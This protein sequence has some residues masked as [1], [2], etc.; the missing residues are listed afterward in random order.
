[1][2]PL[3]LFGACAVTVMLI[4]YALEA[5]SRWWIVVFAAAC[6]ASSAYGWLSGTWP[7]GVIEG[8]WSLIALQRFLRRPRVTA[9]TDRS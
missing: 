5:R 7:F 9:A 4:A 1:M 6:A 2:S 3:T 8:L